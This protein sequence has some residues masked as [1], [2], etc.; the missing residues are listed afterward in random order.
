MRFSA[1]VLCAFAVPLYS[2]DRVVDTNSNAWVMYFGDHAVS[3]RWGVHLEGQWRRHDA[4]AD[5][6]QLL[7]RPAVNYQ[8]T[9]NVLV[10]A[11]YAF[12]DTHR[13]GDFPAPFRFPE[14]RIFQQ[15]VL[16]NRINDRLSLSHRYRLE[17]RFIG[18]RRSTPGEERGPRTWRYENRFRYM[19]RAATPLADDGDWYLALYDEIF[20]NFGRNVG[21]NFFDQN[22]AYLAVGRKTGG[23]GNLEVGYLNQIVQ[24]R[25]GRV[26]ESNHTFQVGWF[27]TLAFR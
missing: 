16:R 5:W 11:G 21:Q 20:V 14:H 3:D 24:H 17:Q 4:F 9:E 27:S 18:G 8:L 23:W 6:Q 13:Y 1:I 25:S 12:V 26:L 10:T 22:R 2:Q 15:A 19:L 7:L